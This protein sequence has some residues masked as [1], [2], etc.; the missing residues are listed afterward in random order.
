MVGHKICFESTI[1]SE[2]SI[3][4]LDKKGIKRGKQYE[5]EVQSIAGWQK[6]WVRF[7]V[8]GGEGAFQLWVP[9]AWTALGFMLRLRHFFLKLQLVDSIPPLPSV[10]KPSRQTRRVETSEGESL[11]G[12]GLAVQFSGGGGIKE[13]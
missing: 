7:H 13:Q 12:E 8:S 2:D 4:G 10:T 3:V 11:G 5:G 9:L 1:L 6:S